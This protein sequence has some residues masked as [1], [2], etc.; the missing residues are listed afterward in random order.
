[1]QWG[2]RV[3]FAKFLTRFSQIPQRNAAV[4]KLL[5]LEF[6]SN[7]RRCRSVQLEVRCF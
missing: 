6:K 1:M 3:F 4:F 5:L 2:L 7:L